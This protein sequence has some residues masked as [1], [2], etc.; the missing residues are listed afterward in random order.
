MFFMRT[1]L[2]PPHTINAGTTVTFC[3][4]DGKKGPEAVN[5]VPLN[6]RASGIQKGNMKGSQKGG[7]QHQQ[8]PPFQFGQPPTSQGSYYGTIKSWN[9]ERGWGFISCEKTFETYQKDIF[10]MRTALATNTATID[11]AVQFTLIM[12]QKGPEAANVK[13]IPQC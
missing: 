10:V 11:E 4:G 13:P 8:Q 1:E 6:S 3:V 12:G 2:P 9:E 5:I 7:F